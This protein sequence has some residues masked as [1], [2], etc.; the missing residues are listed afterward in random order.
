MARIP[1][2][3]QLQSQVDEDQ[4]LSAQ[5][6]AECCGTCEAGSRLDPRVTRKRACVWDS[7]FWCD[8]TFAVGCG[9]CWL[10]MKQVGADARGHV[11]GWQGGEPVLFLA[12]DAVIHR[13]AGCLLPSKRLAGSAGTNR[14]AALPEGWVRVS[15]SRGILRI[16]AQ[17]YAAICLAS[18]ARHVIQPGCRPSVW[19]FASPR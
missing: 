3:S 19:C 13:A 18:A 16:M 10:C 11:Q 7:G 2:H 15:S 8:G 9:W 4:C 12:P 14:R 1:P 6:M 17:P 5:T